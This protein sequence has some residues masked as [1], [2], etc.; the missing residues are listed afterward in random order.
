MSVGACLRLMKSLHLH[1]LMSLL[2][3]RIPSFFDFFFSFQKAS[4]SSCHRMKSSLRSE[5]MTLE[6]HSPTNYTTEEDG[7]VWMMTCRACGFSTGLMRSGSAFISTSP[8]IPVSYPP[9]T[10]WHTWEPNR[11]TTRTLTSTTGEKCGTAFSADTSTRR[12]STLRRS[13]CAPAWWV[14]ASLDL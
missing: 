10:Q 1:S 14:L 11:A 9:H 12:A 5:W 6:N 2:C 3:I 8:R 4:S 13:A 7:E